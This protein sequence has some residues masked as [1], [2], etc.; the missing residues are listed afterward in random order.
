MREFDW[1]AFAYNG[2]GAA[3][4][5]AV[6][7]GPLSISALLAALTPCVEPAGEVSIIEEQVRWGAGVAAAFLA[8]RAFGVFR[9]P[10][11]RRPMSLLGRG[12]RKRWLLVIVGVALAARL[13]YAL[14]AP[15]PPISDE[16][17]YDVLAR[18]VAAGRGYVEDGVA[19]AYWPV[20]YPALVAA[21]YVAFGFRYLLI[22]IFQCVLGAATAG[23]TW[24][25]AALFLSE[26]SARAAGL[27]VALLPSQVA[28]AARLF[29]VVLLGFAAVAA[30]YLI[31][32]Y[33][34]LIAATTAGLINGA[35]ALAAPVLLPL[36]GAFFVID[37]LVGRGSR[38]ALTRAFLAA[39]VTAAVVAPWTYRNWRV[40]GTFIPVSTNG[41]VILWMGNNAAADG[42]YNF[43][44][45]RANPLYLVRDEVRRD[46]LGRKLAWNYIR[47]HPAAFIKLVVP[48]FANLYATD[49]SAFQYGEAVYGT[50]VAVSARGFPARLAQGLYALL[51]LGFVVALVKRRRR[52]FSF[53][54]GKL[55]LAAVLVTPAYLTAFY[56]VFHGLDRYHFPMIPFMAVVAAAWLEAGTDDGH[57]G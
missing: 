2:L 41:G 5:A 39:A 19:T 45:C 6:A 18:S 4:C 48:K 25:F 51:W 38:R 35:A 21:F 1:R 46:R 43:P 52:I 47:H 44:L 49:T 12:G 15:P 54:G 20:G 16:V 53:V 36:P 57:E 30:S 50:D 55:P 9:L 3:A 40:F 14:A 56:L 37:L 13:A 32:K 23:L 26:S 27:I 22:I 10:L 17:H 31:V 29:P 11:F 7:A 42:C 24:R 28:Y 8:L 34:S 33:G